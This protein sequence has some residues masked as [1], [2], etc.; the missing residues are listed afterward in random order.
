MKTQNHLI[1][2]I[3][4][5]IIPL[6]VWAAV[7]YQEKKRY[8]HVVTVS[9]KTVKLKKLLASDGCI[10]VVFVGT[11]GYARNSGALFSLLIDLWMDHPVAKIIYA[12]DLYNNGMKS[13]IITAAHW[14][15]KHTPAWLQR[16]LP[17]CNNLLT[18][19][20]LLPLIF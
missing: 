5:H 2:Y 18:L 8:H 17:K 1:S 6:N 16:R 3:I 14:L 4:V 20:S 11:D 10:E 12:T 19:H 13:P 7:P 9:G 15:V